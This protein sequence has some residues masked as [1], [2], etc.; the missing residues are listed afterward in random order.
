MWEI[1][2]NVCVHVICYY[3]LLSRFLIFHI[4]VFCL[5]GLWLR[6]GLRSLLLWCLRLLRGRGC[7]EMMNGVLEGLELYLHLINGQA[8][9][10]IGL[11]R[12]EYLINN[13]EV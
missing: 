10:L 11:L 3:S 8:C 9:V 7:E 5:G 4:D 1:G 13:I 12:G 6:R 2:Y